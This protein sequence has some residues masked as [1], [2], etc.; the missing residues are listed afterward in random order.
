MGV[1]E[2]VTESVKEA[3]VEIPRIM[4]NGIH[5][6]SNPIRRLVGGKEVSCVVNGLSEGSLPNDA[7]E[8]NTDSYGVDL[9]GFWRYG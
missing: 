1:G 9:A 4:H 8:R 7:P 5:L 2:A 6:G 3:M